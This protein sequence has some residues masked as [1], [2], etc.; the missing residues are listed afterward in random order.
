M[1]C[2]DLNYGVDTEMSF[3][4]FLSAL[5]GFCSGLIQINAL[6]QLLVKWV[7]APAIIWRLLHPIIFAFPLM[8]LALAKGTMQYAIH[9]P[10]PG[11]YPVRYANHVLATASS[12]LGYATN[13]VATANSITGRAS[14]I[15]AIG[16]MI[17]TKGKTILPT[18]LS[19]FLAQKPIF[20]PRN[21]YLPE[22]INRTSE[23]IN[24]KYT[25]GSPH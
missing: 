7:Q 19:T 21:G 17:L 20:N 1:V 10:A 24:L 6:K 23:I 8:I 15:L 16:K 13:M 22:L 18:A 11:R 2:F 4:I 9:I 25:Y 12:A 14:N 3:S 5:P